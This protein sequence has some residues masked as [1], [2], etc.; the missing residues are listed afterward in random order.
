MTAARDWNFIGE[1]IN[2][3]ARKLLAQDIKAGSMKLVVEG[4]RL[5]WSGAPIL[6]VNMGS[7]IDEAEAMSKA[8]MEIQAAVDCPITIDSTPILRP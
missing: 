5:R 2:P 6:D 4:S 8:V 7:G 1:R 3:T